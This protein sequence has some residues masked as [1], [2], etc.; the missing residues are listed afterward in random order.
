M[1]IT[2]Q[3]LKTTL[4]IYERSVDETIAFEEKRKAEQSFFSK[5]KKID[6]AKISTMDREELIYLPFPWA[7]DAVHINGF[8]YE[9]VDAIKRRY[10]E[11]RLD[12][13][14]NKDIGEI[15]K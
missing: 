12:K 4:E 9:Y 13:S 7:I 11:L 14:L 3:W 8:A 1:K 10:E 5:L 15:L 6:V 2:R